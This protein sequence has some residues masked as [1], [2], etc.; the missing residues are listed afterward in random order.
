MWRILSNINARFKLTKWANG[1]LET[2][3]KARSQ[4]FVEHC[5]GLADQWLGLMIGLTGERFSP[6]VG[7]GGDQRA[8]LEQEL[9]QLL[10]TEPLPHSQ[11]SKLTLSPMSL[12]MSGIAV[13]SEEFLLG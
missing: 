7:A 10:C 13:S 11:I 5:N 3:P 4:E 12:N 8:A 1:D 2:E 9:I 6:W